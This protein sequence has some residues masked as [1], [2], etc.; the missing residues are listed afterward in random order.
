[1]A[2]LTE[3][4]IIQNIMVLKSPFRDVVGLAGEPQES[5]LHLEADIEGKQQV[6]PRRPAGQCLSQGQQGWQHSS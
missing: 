6:Q 4:N 3:T 5:A 1:M 2:G